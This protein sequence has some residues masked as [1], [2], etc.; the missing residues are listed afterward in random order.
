M[1][2][3]IVLLFLICTIPCYSQNNNAALI[4]YKQ[5]FSVNLSPSLFIPVNLDTEKRLGFGVG[6]GVQWNYKENTSLCLDYDIAYTVTPGD[7]HWFGNEWVSYSSKWNTYMMLTAGVKFYFPLNEKLKLFCTTGLGV[8]SLRKR[9]NQTEVTPCIS[10]EIGG[11][12]KLNNNFSAFCK[13][14]NSPQ[15]KIGMMGGSSDI[16]A[17][18]LINCGI[19]YQF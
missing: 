18:V 17:V 12:Y 3:V 19:G 14:K 11:Q 7:E 9:A 13:L 16:G 8:L 1:N 2:K 5:T 6:L 15:L 10:F 4:P